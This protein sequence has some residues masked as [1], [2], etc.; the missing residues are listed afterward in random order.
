MSA[1][2]ARQW[3]ATPDQVILDLRAEESGRCLSRPQPRCF[4]VKED[5]GTILIRE[6]EIR[7]RWT[8]Y[9]EQLYRVDFRS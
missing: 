6:S 8:G 1:E 9:F 7:A 4:T 2:S 5:D 3:R